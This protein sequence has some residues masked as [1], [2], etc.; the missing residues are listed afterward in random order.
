[1]GWTS[2]LVFAL[3]TH[4][5]GSAFS[6]LWSAWMGGS[7]ERYARKL[8]ELAADNGAI[9]EHPGR[10]AVFKE[11]S[12]KI[13]HWTW[14]AGSV[15]VDPFLT[16]AWIMM[17]SALIYVGARI[18][19]TPKAGEPPVNFESALKIVSY[20]TAPSILSAIP[21]V[22]SG[23]AAIYAA[24]VTVIGA[25]EVYRIS[26]GRAIVVGLFPKFLILAIMFSGLAV[27]A[28]ILLKLIAGAL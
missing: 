1:M 21:L 8:L 27:L 10:D 26:I 15:V 5:I 4:W 9:I 20:G 24:Y 17:T 14:G 23:L 16:L 22:G 19:V 2:P 6:F 28:V 12:E 18:L 13:D 11:F 25:R 7:F 3:V